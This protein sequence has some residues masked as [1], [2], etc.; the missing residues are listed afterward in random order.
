MKQNNVILIEKVFLGLSVS[1]LCFYLFNPFVSFFK[2]N[3]SDYLISPKLFAEQKI[4]HKWH[5]FYDF[6]LFIK[7]V[8]PDDSLIIIPTIPLQNGAEEQSK[9]SMKS[10]P[11][12]YF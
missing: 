5:Y 8:T 9:F 2:K 7:K 10:D 11:H 12:D 1:L 3:I 6:D 4:Y